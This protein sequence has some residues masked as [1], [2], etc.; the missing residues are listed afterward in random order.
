MKAVGTA[1]V[2]GVFPVQQ[3]HEI[4]LDELFHAVD[5]HNQSIRSQLPPGRD[6]TFMLTHFFKDATAG[7]CTQPMTH[8]QLLGQA[9]PFHPETRHHAELR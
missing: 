1:P 7:F 3:A 8:S 5:L 4:E 9:L 2:H 6:D